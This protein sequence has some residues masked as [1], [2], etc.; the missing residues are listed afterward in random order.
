MSLESPFT[1]PPL[2]A[3]LDAWNKIL[4]DR[5]F[6]TE[7]LWLFQEN[8]CLERSQAATGGFRFGFQTQFTPPPVDALDLAYEH[9]S[10]T[11]ARMVFYR[12]G[13][14]PDHSVCALLCDERFEDKAE[15]DG[16]LRHDH[17]KISFH[18]GEDDQIEEVTE[19]SRWL[20]RVKHNRPF[21]E[22]DFAM[23]LETVDEIKIYG[24]PL[25]PYE[26]FADHMVRRLRRI[27]G[28]P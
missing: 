10:G 21:H 3:A 23:S 18:P 27:L 4:A 2:Q 20:R 22:L 7:Q 17:W 25:L 11:E 12:L 16:F 24:R 1:R 14:S 26:R 6:S 13:S 28:Q 15:A 5:D 19:L 9:F 8:L